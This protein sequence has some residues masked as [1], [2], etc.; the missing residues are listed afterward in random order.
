[1]KYGKLI[2]SVLNTDKN[3][4]NI[5][6]QCCQQDYSITLWTTLAKERYEIVSTKKTKKR[7][8]LRVKQEFLSCDKVELQMKRNVSSLNT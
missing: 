7:K 6:L 5:I 4:I 8:K 1:M 3:I 2:I